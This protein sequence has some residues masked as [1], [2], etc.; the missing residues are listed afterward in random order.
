[1]SLPDL[2]HGY[3]AAHLSTLD[4]ACVCL[5][6]RVLRATYRPHITALLIQGATGQIDEVE[7]LVR[8]LRC[9]TVSGKGSQARV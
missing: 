7:A 9:A 2:A 3:I 1:L 6:S 8:L 4:L 5:G